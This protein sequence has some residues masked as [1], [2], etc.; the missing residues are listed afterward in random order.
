MHP[1][2]ALRRLWHRLRQ[3]DKVDELVEA[4]EYLLNE[5]NLLRGAGRP[6]I[7]YKTSKTGTI[8][9]TVPG[10]EIKA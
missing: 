9:W 1:I 2:L 6:I 8:A 10:K 5:N 7:A 3:Q 4:V